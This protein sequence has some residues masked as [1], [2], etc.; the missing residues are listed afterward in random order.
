[1]IQQVAFVIP[2]DIAAKIAVGEYVQYGGVVRDLGGHIVKHL[3]PASPEETANAAQAVAAKAIGFAR[4]NKA[5]A[6]GALAVAGVAAVGGAVYA[7]VSHFRRKRE[8]EAQEMLV[9]AFNAAL[10]EYLEA[11]GDEDLTV[12]R[13]DALEEA[14][15]AL[16]NDEAGFTIEIGGEQFK[17]LVRAVREYTDRLSRANGVKGTGAILRLFEKKPDDMAGLR[18]CLAAQREI[19]QAA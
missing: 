3:K 16:D 17:T 5:L 8:R 19:L 11:L 9:D 12:E 6:A 7:G 13:V 18:E 2:P 15:S 4:Q 14:I 10:S 1:M